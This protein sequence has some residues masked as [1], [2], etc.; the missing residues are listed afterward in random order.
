MNDAITMNND[1]IRRK[2][3][4]LIKNR[5][6]I[7]DEFKLENGLMSV[8]AALIYTGSGR[9]ADVEKLRECRKILKENAGAL[10]TFRNTFELAL[11]SKM[12]LS[13]DPEKYLEDVMSVYR[14]ILNGKL[15][16]NPYMILAAALICD[17]KRQ[18]EADDII[19]KCDELLKLMNKKHPVL[20]SS[21]D[22]SYAM[23]LA[24][25]DRDTDSI[26]NDMEECRVYLKK[27]C[28]ISAGSNAIQGLSE[29][30]ALTDRDMK[31]SCDRIAGIINLLKERKIDYGTDYEFPAFGLLADIDADPE[32]LVDGVIE[33][34][35]ILKES[36]GFKDSAMEKEKR[37]MYAVMLVAQCYGTEPAATDNNAINATLEIIKSKQIS[38]MISVITSLTSSLAELVKPDTEEK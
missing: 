8:A 18:N 20:T 17:R 5:S 4:L 13:A 22:I 26:I 12:A 24:L 29:I 25:S 1:A 7:H 38:T 23:M 10:S 30:L 32:S 36:G 19:A 37:L 3:E 21:E 9:E 11:L 31:A 35:G 28:K 2:C 14:W 15:V 16:D 34:E 33:A 6:L 27:T